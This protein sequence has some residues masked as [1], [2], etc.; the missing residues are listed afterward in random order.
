MSD[1]KNFTFAPAGSASTGL[2]LRVIDRNGE[3]WFV[4]KDVCEALGLDTAKGTGPRL[5]HLDPEETETINLNSVDT[6]R[7]KKAG[8]P[9]ATIINESGLYSLIL[10]SRKPEARAFKKCVTSEVLP[11]IRKTGGYMAPSVAL[12]TDSRGHGHPPMTTPPKAWPLE[13]SRTAHSG[14]GRRREGETLRP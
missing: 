4:A 7:G 3:P 2:E 8:N 10:R 5:A 9:R 1:I 11:T 14:P 13:A 12:S 6:N